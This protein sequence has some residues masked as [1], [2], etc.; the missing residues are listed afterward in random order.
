VAA[1]AE[2]ERDESWLDYRVS[3][4]RLFAFSALL[5]IGGFVGFRA[6]N[7]FGGFRINTVES[8]TPAFDPATYRFVVD[9]L[10]EQPLSLTYDQLL[11]LPSVK[12][13]CDF[14]CVEGW[15]VKDVRW[16]GVRLQTL[17]EMARPRANAAFITFHSLDGVYLD[18]LAVGQA[19]YPDALVAYR[20]DDQ[21]L[22]PDHGF[23][24]R[25][26]MPHMYGYKGAKYLYRM[27]FS[28]AQVI[29]YWEQRG[30]Q[31]NGW[32]A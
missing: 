30:W 12:Q 27:E 1:L 19:S 28:P 22:T 7:A 13:V 17:M 10:V 23:P 15:A 16:E 25:F 11:G 4:R 2:G 5:G 9:G 6:L 8:K 32:L 24:L 29:G 18:S 26:V 31:I 14:H 21:P 20:M 3:R